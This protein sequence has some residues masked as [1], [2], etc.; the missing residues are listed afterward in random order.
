MTRFWTLLS[1]VIGFEWRYVPLFLASGY[2]LG[3]YSSGLIFTFFG[4]DNCFFFFLNP[5]R[6]EISL[7]F[8]PLGYLLQFNLT[9]N[10]HKNFWLLHF[11]RYKH[12]FRVSQ[13]DPLEVSE[14]GHIIRFKDSSSQNA[15]HQGSM[16]L[17]FILF[18]L[19]AIKSEDLFKVVETFSFNLMNE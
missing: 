5:T 15:L 6:M 8:L 12:M 13:Q 18:L 19:I 17:S 16:F 7:P 4:P 2:S 10:I 1:I 11:Y 9:A 14:Q 3:S